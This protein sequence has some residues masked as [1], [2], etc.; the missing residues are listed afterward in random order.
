MEREKTPVVENRKLYFDLLRILA[1]FSVVMLHSAAQFWHVLPV[2]GMGWKIVNAYDACFRFGVPVFVMISGALFLDPGRELGLGKLYR[3]SILRLVVLYVVWSGIYGLLTCAFSSGDSLTWRQVLVNMARGQ[4]HL[5]YLPMLVGIYMLLPVLRCWIL[6]AEEQNIR[7][8]LILFVLLQVLRTTVMTFVENENLRAVLELGRIEMTCSYLGYFVL[9]YY[10]VYVGIRKRYHKYLYLS[11]IPS[12][13]LNILISNA[14]T[15]RRGS[16]SGEIYDS[17]G[18]FTF[19]IT[20]AVFLFFAE[21]VKRHRFGSA[22]SAV[23]REVSGGTLGIYLTHV[24]VMDL[25]GVWGIDSTM[26]PVAGVPVFAVIVFAISYILAALLR[27]IPVIG[28]YI[29]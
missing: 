11:V 12:A 8:F 9:G 5:W 13:V 14:Q 23:I 16:P 18:L 4:I 25:L 15:A 6:H 26:I 10:I 2:T 21:V 20:T 7:Y 27:R 24:G 22:G 28:R 29:C 1:A 17:Y 3:H 19:L